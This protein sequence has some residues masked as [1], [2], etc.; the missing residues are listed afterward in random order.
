MRLFRSAIGAQV[1]QRAT[2]LVGARGARS[3]QRAAVE[4]RAARARDVRWGAM[5]RLP[6]LLLLFFFA[7]GCGG[8]DFPGTHA[9][10]AQGNFFEGASVVKLDAPS[11]TVEVRKSGDDYAM[12]VRGCTLH[13]ARR[14]QGLVGFPPQR[15]DFD[16][17]GRGKIA[18]TMNG[19]M[20]AVTKSPLHKLLR[21]N[22]TLSGEDTTTSPARR[23]TYL[24][25]PVYDPDG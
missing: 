17:P 13:G 5:R 16:V 19:Q 8:R 1:V 6:L 2:A 4:D 25:E 20:A 12:T 22:V 7:A 10:R 24:V 23:L 11:E 18:L 3:A 14:G 9:G 15:C 21:A